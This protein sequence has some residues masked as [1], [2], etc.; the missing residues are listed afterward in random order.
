MDSR[1]FD[2]AREQFRLAKQVN[3]LAPQIDLTMVMLA[4]AER[5]YDEAIALDRKLLSENNN[6]LGH[7]LLAFLYADKKQ[8]ETAVE[9]GEKADALAGD[10]ADTNLALADLYAQ[11]GQRDKAMPIMRKYLDIGQ[12]GGFVPPLTMAGV[13]AV[14]GDREQMYQWLDKGIEARSLGMLRLDVAEVVDP[15]RSEPRFQEILRKI[16]LPR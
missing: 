13:Y 6:A 8:Y 7:L 11:A 12:S 3:P 16:G 2:E 4:E 9:E 5:K 14:L 10:D 1:R 15:Y